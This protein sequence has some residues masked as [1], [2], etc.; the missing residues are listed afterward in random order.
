MDLLPLHVRDYDLYLQR[1][2][3]FSVPEVPDGTANEAS[4]SLTSGT[5][6]RRLSGAYTYTYFKPTVRLVPTGQHRLTQHQ[7]GCAEKDYEN[8]QISICD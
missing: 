2:R 7:F 1:Q 6:L 3:H 5:C 4:L 8:T